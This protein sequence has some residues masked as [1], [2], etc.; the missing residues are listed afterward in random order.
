MKDKW[1][2][3][4]ALIAGAS[5]LPADWLLADG[6]LLVVWKGAGV[7]LLALW[8]ARQARS[9]EGWLLAAIMALGA[10]GDVLLEVAGLTTGAIAFLAGHLVAIALYAR[11]LRPLRWQA[12]APIAVG[13]LL[14]IPLL[15]FVFPADRAAAPGIALY[16]TGLGAM[17]AMA[18]L[19]S[20]PRNWVSFGALLFAVSDLLIFARLGPLTGSIIPDLLVWPLYFGGQAMIAWGVAA[21]LARRRAK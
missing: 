6:P 16:A 15:A 13:R 12:D 8:A 14:I 19:S 4:A 9:L 7:A 17:A 3:G 1:L 18:W 10:A 5:Y 11:N 2:L 21:A 20:F